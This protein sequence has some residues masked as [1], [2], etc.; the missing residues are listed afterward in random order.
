MQARHREPQEGPRPSRIAFLEQGRAL[1]PIAPG[2]SR[3]GARARSAVARAREDLGR[4]RRV[5][6]Q[7]QQ[8]PAQGRFGLFRGGQEVGP[9]QSAKAAS[10]FVRERLHEPR[11]RD[12]HG[13]DDVEPA[14]RVE[15]RDRV[16]LNTSWA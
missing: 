5:A 16:H 4:A 9:V 12:R 2:E 11:A 13:L 1:A 7:P 15:T 10:G 6:G 14:R 8:A 3:A